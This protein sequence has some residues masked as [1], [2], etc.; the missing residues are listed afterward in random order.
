MIID[1]YNRDG[2]GGGYVLPTATRTRLGGVKVG[3][4]LTIDNSGVLSVSGGTDLSDYWTSAQ[5]ES[6][7]TN[8]IDTESARTDTAIADAIAAETARTEQVYLKEHQSLA[9]YY[10]SAQ[11]Q[12]AITEAT[13]GIVKTLNI[14]TATSGE[15]MEFYNYAMSHHNESYVIL[16]H[17]DKGDDGF[18][19]ATEITFDGDDNG[20][21]LT[22]FRRSGKYVFGFWQGGTDIQIF[23]DENFVTTNQKATTNDL[24]LIKV[25]SGLTIDS[26]GTLSAEGGSGVQVV[27]DLSDITN[28]TSGMT[29]LIPQGTPYHGKGWRFVPSESIFQFTFIDN[30]QHV[31][32][33]VYFSSQNEMVF[34]VNNGQYQISERV[35]RD[36]NMFEG[37]SYAANAVV[38][39]GYSGTSVAYVDVLFVEGVDKWM[40]LTDSGST[41]VTPIE[42]DVLVPMIDYDREYVYRGATLVDKQI[43][44]YT[45]DVSQFSADDNVPVADIDVTSYSK[46]NPEEVVTQSIYIGYQYGP[47]NNGVECFYVKSSDIDMAI[48]LTD[49]NKWRFGRLGRTQQLFWFKQSGTTIYV[50][51]WLSNEGSVLSAVTVSYQRGDVSTAPDN[52]NLKVVEGWEPKHTKPFTLTD[53]NHILLRHGYDVTLLLYKTLGAFS[54]VYFQN[55]SEQAEGIDVFLFNGNN[56]FGTGSDIEVAELPVKGIMRV[57]LGDN[58]QVKVTAQL[59]QEESG[60]WYGDGFDW[61]YSQ[62]NY[63]GSNYTI[64]T[65]EPW[66]DEDG[67]LRFGDTEYSQSGTYQNILYLKNL[68]FIVGSLNMPGRNELEA[69]FPIIP[70]RPVAN[71]NWTMVTCPT[72]KRY[73]NN[74]KDHIELNYTGYRLS[75]DLRTWWDFPGYWITEISN[76]TLTTLS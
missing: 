52:T 31:R 5:T 48:A 23:N 54:P 55:I 37:F 2:G 11:T 70:L 25:G 35:L 22:F 14:S 71:D 19:Q 7:I 74:D 66:V 46:F 12:S 26:G 68:N 47:Y 33:F 32:I 27:T 40:E 44:G 67:H 57:M 21:Y 3:S 60:I 73:Q 59:A 75:F 72:I 10:T 4:G 34:N 61:S 76:A 51:P 8:A 62:T 39:V 65:Q 53:Y 24:G 36:G 38:K 28:P 56:S 42:Y 17:L 69:C 45:I 1:F 41:T 15:C 20:I 16:Y 64:F 50:K 18:A 30:E 9:D 6:A 13:S 58:C 63:P 43:S 29:A 49:D